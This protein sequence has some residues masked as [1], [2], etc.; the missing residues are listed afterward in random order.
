[1]SADEIDLSLDIPSVCAEKIIN[2]QVDAGLIPVAELLKLNDYYIFSRFCIGAKGTVLSVKLYSQVPMHDIETVLLDFHSKTSINLTKVL[3]KNHWKKTP[4]YLNANEGYISKIENSTAAV[5]IGD[6]TFKLNGT[7]NYEYDLSEEWEKMTDL[8][9]AFALWVSRKPLN[10]EWI[11]KFDSA[12]EYGLM[13]R[14]S[15]IVPKKA[16]F[17][18]VDLEEYVNN[19]IDYEFDS[20]KQRALKLFHEL[21][22]NL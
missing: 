14:N 4:L 6:R 17:P 16:E 3:M 7:F 11:S 13:H 5:V 18:L 2:G 22:R 15:A 21:M 12:L 19:Y 10:T 20:E 9:F 1:M 8:P